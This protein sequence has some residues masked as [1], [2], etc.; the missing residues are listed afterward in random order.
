MALKR[1]ASWS[2]WR[3]GEFG[4]IGGQDAPAGSFTGVNVMVTRD[5]SIVPRQGW[6][7]VTP[8]GVIAG[9]TSGLYF[10]GTTNKDLTWVQGTVVRQSPGAVGGG[11][12][13]NYAGALA[14]SPTKVTD[15]FVVNQI[16]YL[17]VF[18]DK[19][20]RLD[21]VASTLAALTG[22]PPGGRAVCVYGDRLIVGGLSGFPNRIQISAAANFNSWPSTNIID[23]GGD[24]V[25]IR[26]LY[27]MRDF[28]VIVRADGSVYVL[29]GVPTVNETVRKIVGFPKV[30]MGGQVLNA[31]RAAMDLSNDTIWHVGLH[32]LIPVRYNGARVQTIPE[33]LFAPARTGIDQ[34]D[35]LVP[36]YGAAAGSE[37]DECI[38]TSK[39]DGAFATRRNG[40]WTK[41]AFAAA[42]GANQQGYLQGDGGDAVYMLGAVGTTP[43]IMRMAF[44]DRNGAAPINGAGFFAAESAGDL[45]VEVNFQAT[46]TMPDIYAGDD[47]EVI[48][49]HVIVDFETFTAGGGSVFTNHFDVTV[50][51]LGIYEG[52]PSS[53]TKSFDAAQAGGSA[54]QRERRRL[55]FALGRGNGFRV[56]LDNLRGVK[57]KR[58]EVLAELE[59]VRAV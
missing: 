54:G 46:A 58:V 22:T 33:L 10:T 47:N 25:E 51:T 2:S 15:G 4:R 8:A 21:A 23:I 14:V 36:S 7:D 26:A 40:A 12:I 5:G 50:T 3:R 31:A 45:S 29:T 49:R 24:N 42:I 48:V 20:Y 30:A 6:R 13:V 53:E 56:S 55:S 11:A 52:Q 59:P 18:G 17:T 41:H 16:I 27:P 57:I 9:A 19:T 34:T 1:V 37:R 39:P 35:G 44:A 43:K 38:L 28:L 32:E